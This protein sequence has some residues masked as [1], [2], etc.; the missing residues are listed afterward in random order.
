ME[1]NYIYGT[2]GAGVSPG[3]GSNQV[4]QFLTKMMHDAL[5]CTYTLA[6]S[7]R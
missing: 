5:K 4:R 1:Q 2:A 6:V 7:T 3:Q